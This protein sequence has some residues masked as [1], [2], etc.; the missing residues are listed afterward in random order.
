MVSLLARLAGLASLISMAA[1]SEADITFNCVGYPS[2][3]GG[4]FG[5]SIG[6]AITKLASTEA[7]FPVWSGAVPGTTSAAQYSYVELNA[8][9][10]A[11]RTEAFIRTIR[12][13]T[14]THTYNEFFERQTTKWVLPHVPYSYLATWPSYT[15][16]F[17]D[18]VI[19]TIH[20]TADPA[21]MA[22]LNANPNL[23]TDIK[24]NFRWIDHK[25]IYSQNNITFKTS[26]KSSKDFQ[27][28]AYKFSFD[29]NFN[30][31]FF[32]RPNIKLR[33]EVTDPTVMREKLYIDMLNAVGV[34]TQQ[35][36]YV[37]LFINSQPYGLY[38]MVD[39]IKKSF[40]KQ[41]VY[42]GDPAA[43]IGSL[44]QMNAPT[45]TNQ[46]DLVYKGPTNASYD[47]VVYADVSLGNNP[48][49]QPLNQLIT[50]MADLQAFD[51]VA[52]P[53]PIGYWNNTRL[54]LDGF[55]RNMALEYL[56]G[57]FDNYWMSGSNYFMYFNAQLGSSGKWQW[58]P[59]DFDGTFGNGFPT[60]KL[61][62][63]QTFYSF[64]P[65]HPLVSKLIIKNKEINALFEQT[66]KD[67]VGWSFKPEGLFPRIM[68]YNQM[69]AE[70]YKWDLAIARTGPGVNNNYTF[71]DFNNNL[72][73]V[74]KDMQASLK[75][76]ITDASTLVAA[77][78]SFTIQAGAADRVA[79]PPKPTHN[80][81]GDPKGDNNG[82]AMFSGSWFLTALA[83]SASL[84]TLF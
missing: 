10:A 72:D 35:S 43:V 13:A 26:G 30:Q 63:Y 47:P 1:L 25:M 23:P 84:I 24:V 36:Q 65:D 15:K 78:L 3:A 6:G 83:V 45:V 57:A 37:R 55:L 73:N 42:Q 31:S 11:V 76:W 64:T 5:V 46:A 59:T 8:A 2:T 9:G 20:V 4:S 7:N 39:D 14:D 68:A 50:F 82:A 52:T 19:A 54:D 34:P 56:A 71:D 22:A 53:D 81:D 66:L 41:T 27:K 29:T 48:V 67:I 77:Q 51:P 16:I 28:Q 12:N 80:K 44:V 61:S 58:I 49:D 21:Q 75:G 38:L 18:D 70:D 32:S 40:I 74:T 33:S 79:P 60:S 17:D 62:S 69:L